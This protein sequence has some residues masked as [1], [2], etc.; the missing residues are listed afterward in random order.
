MWVAHGLEM[1][2]GAGGLET[3]AGFLFGSGLLLL[4]GLLTGLAL[5]SQTQR[6]ALRVAGAAVVYFALVLALL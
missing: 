5:K 6:S 4:A 2:V 3:A 1:P